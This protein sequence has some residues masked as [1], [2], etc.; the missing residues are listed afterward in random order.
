MKL[1]IFLGVIRKLLFEFH[2]GTGNCSC[3][4]SFIVY[5]IHFE[6]TSAFLISATRRHLLYRSDKVH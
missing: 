6:K 5:I 2:E 4:F 3:H 1:E